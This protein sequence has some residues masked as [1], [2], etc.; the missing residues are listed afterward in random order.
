[1]AIRRSLRRPRAPRDIGTVAR[2]STS[3]WTRTQQAVKVSKGAAKRTKG[4]SSIVTD[5]IKDDAIPT[6]I[7]DLFNVAARAV[8]N[9]SVETGIAAVTSMV[10]LPGVNSTKVANVVTYGLRAAAG[11][12]GAQGALLGAMPWIGGGLLLADMIAEETGLWDSSKSPGL[13]DEERETL[14]DEETEKS[15]FFDDLFDNGLLAALEEAELIEKKK[16]EEA[17][18]KEE[19]LEEVKKKAEAEE[20][21]LLEAERE[22]NKQDTGGTDQEQISEIKQ[23]IETQ[24][25]EVRKKK[26]S[27]QELSAEEKEKKTAAELKIAE[28]ARLKAI[29]EERLERLAKGKEPE[30]PLDEWNYKDTAAAVLAGFYHI[31]RFTKR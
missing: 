13:T 6:G 20:T 26:D 3:I 29:E 12:L 22:V 16:I 23:A 17:E 14:Y 5:A 15:Q 7:D 9:P 1:M 10:R 24:K 19:V 4:I 8:T 11:L 30:Q 31:G 27:A 21:A 28:L 25:V 18:E 2:R